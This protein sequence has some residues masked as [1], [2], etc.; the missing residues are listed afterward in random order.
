[1]VEL[2]FTAVKSTGISTVVDN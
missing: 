1:M 2:R